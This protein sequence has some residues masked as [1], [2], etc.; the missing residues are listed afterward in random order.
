MHPHH[1]AHHL[2]L[3]FQLLAGTHDSGAYQLLTPS[4][5]VDGPA[6]QSMLYA[7][8]QTVLRPLAEPWVLTQGLSLTD[9]LM[10]AQSVWPYL[11]QQMMISDG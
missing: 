6:W 7:L 5:V 10:R 9:K 11:S 8:L 1:P 3:P 2:N 4:A